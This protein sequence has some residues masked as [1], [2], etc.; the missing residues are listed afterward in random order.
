MIKLANIG[1][2]PY[3]G[4]TPTNQA[5]GRFAPESYLWRP[6]AWSATNQVPYSLTR[7]RVMVSTDEGASGFKEGSANDLESI[8]RTGF[9]SE[10]VS[11]FRHL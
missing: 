4:N 6:E 1:Y 7:G 2:R 11:G 10:Y 9:G 3:R 5:V 8:F